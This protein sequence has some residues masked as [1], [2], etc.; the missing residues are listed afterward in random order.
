VVGHFGSWG[1][2]LAVG[3]M[4]GSGGGGESDVVCLFECGK[5]ELFTPAQGFKV[6]SFLQLSCVLVP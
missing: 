5:K 2:C 3:M 4:S 6:G 1:W